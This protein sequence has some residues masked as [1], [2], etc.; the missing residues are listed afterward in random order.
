LKNNTD[1]FEIPFGEN[2]PFGT[3]ELHADAIAEVAETN[4][5]YRARLS[6][7]E[8]LQVLLGP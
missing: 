7:P 6:T 2:L 3:Y 8:K 5:I 1:D 4:T